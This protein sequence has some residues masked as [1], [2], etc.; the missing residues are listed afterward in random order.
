[1]SVLE[2][3]TCMYYVLVLHVLSKWTSHKRS[4]NPVKHV[5]ANSREIP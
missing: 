5:L 3:G 1:M 2:M 4:H